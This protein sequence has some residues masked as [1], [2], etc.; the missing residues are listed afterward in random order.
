MQVEFAMNGIR[1]KLSVVCFK[2]VTLPESVLFGQ[3][4]VCI[5]NLTIV[6][7]CGRLNA[8]FG[9][10]IGSDISEIRRR[11]VDRSWKVGAEVAFAQRFAAADD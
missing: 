4:R 10:R 8:G 1:S 2:N 11:A 3:P 5:H 7:K 6:Y 9:L